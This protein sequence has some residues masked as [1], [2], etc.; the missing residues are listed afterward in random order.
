MKKLEMHSESLINE[1][2]AK[3]AELFPECV[4]EVVNENNELEKQVD[5]D[6]FRSLFKDSII[7]GNKERYQF[8]WP[9]KLAAR[10]EAYT[11][12][13]RSLCPCKE[14]SINF[15]TT[16]NLYIE[17]DNLTV[18]K[19]LRHTYH[20]KV[21][22]IYIDPPYNTGNDFVYNDQFKQNKAAYDQISGEY[23][24]LGNRLYTNTAGGG[25]F[26]T[27][28]LNMMYP[29]LLLARDLLAKDGV[30]FISI[31]NNELSNLQKICNELFGEENCQAIITYV[32]KTSGKQDSSN[33]MNSTEYIVVYSKSALWEC[34][35]LIAG[36]N[37]TSRYNKVDEKGRA[38]RETDLRKTGT[39]DRREDRPLMWYPFYYNPSTDSLVVERN[40]NQN[41]V[42]S[43]YVEIYPIKP[44]GTEG[45]WRWGYETAVSNIEFLVARIMPKYAAQ[46]KYTIYEI[47]YIDKNGEVRTVKE[48]TCW[49]RKEFNSDN[50]MQEFK[51][52]GFS[53]QLFPF[54]KSSD[55]LKHIIYLSNAK[56]G[57]FMDFFSGSGTFAQSIFK[58]NLEDGGN[59][60]FIL[61][62]IPELCKKDSEAYKSGYKNICEI[63]KE[64][65]R[66]AGKQI[67][68][69]LQIKNK[70]SLFEEK[71][72]L[73]VGFRVF[74]Q[75]DSMLAD[76]SVKP[77]EADQ[78]T[79]KQ[80]SSKIKN[81]RT[82]EE[83]L[84][85]S[86]LELGVPLSEKIELIS[87]KN[88]FVY[89]VENAN[90]FACFDQEIDEEMVTEVA[91]MKPDY[92]ILREDAIDDSLI[93]NIDSIF[94]VYSKNADVEDRIRIL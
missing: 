26:H 35:P 57:I 52:L 22:M 10:A 87:I 53:N 50:A 73:D 67:V 59:R 80:M 8:T 12:T 43:G 5:F 69:Q 36:E 34:T 90:L 94:K 27:N 41:L 92:F 28:W 31:D 86:M 89:K 83:L 1:N 15:D 75:S 6:V 56:S 14:E 38:Y 63:G 17:G 37:V 20:G 42:S 79:F 4:T 23:D 76:L 64:R 85:Y 72:E 58:Q 74:K 40:Q 29:R 13:D 30:I 32:R 66:R 7:A 21:K 54:P 93:N 68:D 91:K 81:D 44:D 51:S 18:L 88:H 49:D 62:Q 47:D 60:K 71:I 39:G 33:F 55:L 46:N 70:E 65:I 78:L 77:D 84:F 25:H 19:L 11:P 48:H 45:R 16:E 9:G 2:I 24:E 3:L 61:V 82:P